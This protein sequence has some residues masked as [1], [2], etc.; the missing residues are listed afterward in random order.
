VIPTAK[1]EIKPTYSDAPF[2]TLILNFLSYLLCR[3]RPIYLLENNDN[4]FFRQLPAV[5]DQCRSDREI[6][7]FTDHAYILG[8]FLCG[9]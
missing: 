4:S 7:I 2:V 3:L 1:L 8:W 5:V 6:I 9:K